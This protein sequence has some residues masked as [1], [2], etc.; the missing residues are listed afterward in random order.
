MTS[1]YFSLKL[2][3]GLAPW[4]ATFAI[5]VHV[6]KL[7]YWVKTLYIGFFDFSLPLHFSFM[8]KI[9]VILL[10]ELTFFCPREAILLT[11]F[12]LR[13]FINFLTHRIFKIPQDTLYSLF[14][15]AISVFYFCLNIFYLTVNLLRFVTLKGDL[16]QRFQDFL[17]Y[18]SFITECK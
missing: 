15:I 5:D 2:I 3:F 8:L 7:R 6:N 9:P 16:L 11:M 12:I 13:L 14:S 17:N 18:G 1:L 10:F 4:S